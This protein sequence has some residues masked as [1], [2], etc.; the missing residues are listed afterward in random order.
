M[1][2]GVRLERQTTGAPSLHVTPGE[3]GKSPTAIRDVPPIE[4]TCVLSDDKA[5]RG[6]PNLTQHRKR[7]ITKPAIR[8]VKCDEE[9]AT[10]RATLISERRGEITERDAVPTGPRERGHLR[11]E[12]AGREPRDAKL[13]STLDF[14][15][16]Q[17]RRDHRAAESNPRTAEQMK[18]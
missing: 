12:S 2:R 9:L 3:M 14:V 7:V 1:R 5:R 18:R 13:S 16:A 10:F 6:K 11:R 8:V 17:N 15:V 4:P